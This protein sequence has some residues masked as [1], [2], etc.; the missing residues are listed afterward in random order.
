MHYGWTAIRWQFMILYQK[1]FF[2]GTGISLKFV[3]KFFCVIS[4]S[5][6]NAPL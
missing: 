2:N 4:F 5:E 6:V 3:L 1:Y